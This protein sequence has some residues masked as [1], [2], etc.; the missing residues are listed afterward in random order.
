[1]NISDKLSKMLNTTTRLAVLIQH[2]PDE[3]F[4]WNDS[5]P[6]HD[7]N[8]FTIND[9]L[10]SAADAAAFKK[11]AVH[12]VLHFL[13]YRFQSLKDLKSFL[14]P[15]SASCQKVN[16]CATEDGIRHKPWNTDM[17]YHRCNLTEVGI[18][19]WQVMFGKL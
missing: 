8:D 9:I 2:L 16:P 6:S 18:Y 11:R 17:T 13:V 1:M 3:N 4:D 5:T 19:T 14:P 12:F 15:D 10:P 7:V